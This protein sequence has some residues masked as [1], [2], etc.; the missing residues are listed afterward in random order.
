VARS[1]VHRLA[2]GGEV[3][4]E[5]EKF[6]YVAAARMPVPDKAA[7]VVGPPRQAGG[8][9]WLKLCR[10]DG[11]LAEQLFTRRDGDAYKAA[12]RARWGDRMLIEK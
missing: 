8:R 4:W 10:P 9:A 12:R 7:R 3:P 2:K 1:R 6:A 11:T 5:D